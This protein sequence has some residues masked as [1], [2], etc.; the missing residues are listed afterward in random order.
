MKIPFYPCPRL[1]VLILFVF[2]TSLCEAQVNDLSIPF[3]GIAKDYAGNFVNQRNVFIDIAIIDKNQPSTI[4]LEELHKTKT[5]DWG[6]FSISIGK[7]KW[8]NGLYNQL[9]KID[10]STGSHQLQIKMAIEPEAPLPGW[11]YTQHLISLGN[12]SFGV[13]PYA[14]YSFGNSNSYYNQADLLNLKLNISDTSKMLASYAKAT[15]LN[16]LQEKIDN[17]ISIQDTT[18]FLSPYLKKIDL[19]DFVLLKDSLSNYI[20]ST[21]L[22]SINNQL[23]QFIKLSDSAIHYITPTVLKNSLTDTSSLSSRINTKLNLSDTIYLSN[24]IAQKEVLTNKS[25]DI[26]LL[27]D[28]NDIKYPTVKATKDYIDNQVSNG[29]QDATINNKGIVQLAG[30]LTGSSLDPR[31]AINAITTNKIADAAI[32]DAK[33]A[34]GIQASKLGL[35][36]VTNHAQIYNINGL[37]AQEQSFAIPGTYGLAPNWNSVGNLH[38]LNIPMANESAVTAGLISKLDYDHFN[39]A[40][41]NRITSLTTNG[42]VGAATL[43]G[44]TLNIPNYSLSGLSGTINANNFLAGPTNGATGTVQYRALVACIYTQQ[45]I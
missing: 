6:L 21:Q 38:T 28:Y 10:W 26:N 27:S 11:D 3:Q 18:Q 34:S 12:S 37:T 23:G 41:A 36:N 14:L 9:S 15:S 8:L 25:T 33:I 13:V 31:I 7:G 24:R 5:D 4:L 45:C 43:S 1:L 17:K 32:T 39:T 30:D 29:A 35:G 22:N 2:I 20:T 16:K 42:N 40:Y 19:P 44:Q